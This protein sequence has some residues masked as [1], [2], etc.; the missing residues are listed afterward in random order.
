MIG[1][2]VPAGAKNMTEVSVTTPG[3]PASAIVGTSGNSTH[4]SLPVC[5]KHLIASERNC[6]IS[7]PIP[8]IAISVPPES[9]ALNARPD[10]SNGICLMSILARR[11]RNSIAKCEELPTPGEVPIRGPR[12]EPPPGSGS[13]PV[14]GRPG[15]PPGQPRQTFDTDRTSDKTSAE[16]PRAFRGCAGPAD[17]IARPGG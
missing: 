10:P 14:G 4:R 13:R 7:P 17:A 15:D 2:G 9:I 11:L 8:T 16:T 1:A 6:S 3:T 5:A 12:H